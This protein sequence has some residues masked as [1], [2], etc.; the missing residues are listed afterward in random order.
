MIQVGFD[1]YV[2]LDSIRVVGHPGSAPTTR[3]VKDARNKGLLVDFTAGRRCKAFLV[4]DSK[5]I[6]LSALTSDTL[7]KRTRDAKLARLR[8]PA[9]DLLV[10]EEN[11]KNSNQ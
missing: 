4:L 5:H 8:E 9:A 2:S 6:V 11:N 7:A 1:N 10:M 3:L